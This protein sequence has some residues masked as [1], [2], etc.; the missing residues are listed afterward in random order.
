M[1]DIVIFGRAAALHV[2]DVLKPGAAQRD[3]PKDAVD[4][5]LDRLDRLRYS[6]GDLPCAQIRKKLQSTMQLHAAVFRI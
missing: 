2:K 6:E 3:L 5:A 4:F 1:L